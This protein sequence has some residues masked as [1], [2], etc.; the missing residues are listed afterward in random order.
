[1]LPLRLDGHRLYPTARS[2]PSGLKSIAAAQRLPARPSDILRWLVSAIDTYTVPSRHPHATLWLSGE[3]WAHV[4]PPPVSSFQAS[5]YGL[6]LAAFSRCPYSQPRKPAPSPSSSFRA[7][8]H[9][10]VETSLSASAIPE[11]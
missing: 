7:R 11:R 1:M 5:R 4:A 10:P 8:P 6:C 3:N 2:V 9:L